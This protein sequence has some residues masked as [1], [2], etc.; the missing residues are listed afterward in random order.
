[1]L[2]AAAPPWLEAASGEGLV[3]TG[4]VLSRAGLSMPAL[5]PGQ[6]L[7]VVLHALD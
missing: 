4:A 3:A 6:A 7:V 5:A 1:M 2:P